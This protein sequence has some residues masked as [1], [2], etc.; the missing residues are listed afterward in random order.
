LSVAQPSKH[1]ACVAGAPGSKLGGAVIVVQISGPAAEQS[2]A[3]E[4]GAVQ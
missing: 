3:V 1:Q 2:S 4:Q